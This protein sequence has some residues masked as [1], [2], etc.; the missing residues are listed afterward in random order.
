[1]YPLL[2]KGILNKNKKSK[3]QVVAKIEKDKKIEILKGLDFGLTDLDLVG[4]R[5]FS[6][7]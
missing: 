5:F 1:M 7:F 6:S 4:S 3:S 2:N